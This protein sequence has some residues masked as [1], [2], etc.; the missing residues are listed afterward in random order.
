MSARCA[1]LDGAQPWLT[2]ELVPEYAPE[3]NDIKRC[4][5]DLEQHYLAN[6]TFA[7]A[8]PL[9]RAIPDA[10]TRLNHERQLHASPLLMRSA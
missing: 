1:T 9:E 5:R 10:I 7:D 6:R 4:W 8:G 3:L 2:L